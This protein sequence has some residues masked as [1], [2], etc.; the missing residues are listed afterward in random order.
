MLL[1]LGMMASGGFENANAIGT[2]QGTV[3]ER[4]NLGKLNRVIFFNKGTSIEIGIAF[5]PHSLL[6]ALLAL[7]VGP[8]C[9]RDGESALAMIG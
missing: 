1:G 3:G 9:F 5:A 7:P 4:V 8:Q 2:W 6:A